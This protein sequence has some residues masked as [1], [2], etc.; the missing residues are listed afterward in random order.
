MGIFFGKN[1]GNRSYGYS[2]ELASKVERAGGGNSTG[3]AQLLGFMKRGSDQQELRGEEAEQAARSLR[4]AAPRLGRRDRKVVEQIAR[5]AEAA[6]NS[7]RRWL[8]G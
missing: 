6:A 1:T 8:L 4:G 3:A 7:G 2:Q 5:D